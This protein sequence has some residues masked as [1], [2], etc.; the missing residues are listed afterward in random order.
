MSVLVYIEQRGGQLRP[1]SREALGEAVAHRGEARRPGGGRVRGGPRT[2]G[3]RTR[4][5]G[6]ERVLLA[7]HDA[8]AQYEAAGYARAVALPWRR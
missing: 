5:V 8:F 4:R 7:K 3:W 2:R 1:V 6:C